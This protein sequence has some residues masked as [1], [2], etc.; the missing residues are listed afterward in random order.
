DIYKDSFEHLS[1]Q[2]NNVFSRYQ[3]LSHKSQVRAEA[4]TTEDALETLIEKGKNGLK[5]VSKIIWGVW[6]A[7]VIL[8]C[9]KLGETYYAA[10]TSKSELVTPKTTVK[11]S[12]NPTT[13]ENDVISDDNKSSVL[14]QDKT[15]VQMEVE[16]NQAPSKLDI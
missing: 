12:V 2:V 15:E 10:N 11:T 13:I 8:V 6:F 7:S 5:F 3:V 16:G 4:K 9:F 14:Q 1:K